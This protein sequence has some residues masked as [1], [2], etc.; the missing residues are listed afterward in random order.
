[1]PVSGSCWCLEEDEA[2]ALK[3]GW[4]PYHQ[5]RGYRLEDS[6]LTAASAINWGNNLVPA[7]AEGGKILSMMVWDAVEKS[8]MA[9]GSGMPCV[10]RVFLV[11]GDVDRNKELCL[12]G[13][14]FTTV[15]IELPKDWDKL[16]SERGYA[17]LKTF[18]F[19]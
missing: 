17:S 10:Y 8:Q 12:P 13:G 5:Q 15:K 2:A 1:M 7:T 4:K 16:M 3:V 18:L 6:T 19:H 14:G 9:V 11:T